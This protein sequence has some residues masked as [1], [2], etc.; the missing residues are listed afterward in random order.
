MDS[1]RL[2]RSGIVT[3]NDLAAA[4]TY[5]EQ[6]R[7]IIRYELNTT[8]WAIS[9]A[10]SMMT[11]DIPEET[12]MVWLRHDPYLIDDARR[13]QCVLQ[14]PRQ[15][16]ESICQ[17]IRH[18]DH[19]KTTYMLLYITLLKQFESLRG[20]LT[21]DDPICAINHAMMLKMHVSWCPPSHQDFRF[22]DWI[23]A[24]FCRS[25]G[26]SIQEVVKLFKEND[27]SDEAAHNAVIK[28]I[29]LWSNGTFSA[30]HFHKF[31]QSRCNIS[32][33]GYINE[34]AQLSAINA[35]SPETDTRIC[36]YLDDA[37]RTYYEDSIFK[38]VMWTFQPNGPL[39]I[40]QTQIYVFSSALTNDLRMEW[41]R[42]PA[43]PAPL[44]SAEELFRETPRAEE[45]PQELFREPLRAEQQPLALFR[46]RK[47]AVAPRRVIFREQPAPE[48]AKK[49]RNAIT[50]EYVSN[51]HTT[52]YPAPPLEAL[53]CAVCYEALRPPYVLCAN[54][55]L[56]CPK[57]QPRT[58]NKTIC[59]T[60]RSD[61]IDLK[62]IV[63]DKYFANVMFPCAKCNGRFLATDPHW[64]ESC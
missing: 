53:E 63:M 50:L 56:I 47:A 44:P 34:A 11:N 12:S 52:V 18:P 39:R 28:Q 16:I 1:N 23:Y 54:G 55:H 35:I 46:E 60:C 59:S 19:V 14:F 2:A 40:D 15:T 6:V 17:M 37:K 5:I 43:R 27:A 36:Q 4:D 21:E 9:N 57:C 51:I 13:L 58:H 62:C 41:G 64:N 31:N 24:G 3:P 42:L 32:M 38:G 29:L 49:L 10:S 7:S 26:K 8:D 22:H 20:L 30:S 48:P 61:K 45:P 25:C 33:P